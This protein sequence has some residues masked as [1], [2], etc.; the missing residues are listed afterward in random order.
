MAVTSVSKEQY[1]IHDVC[2]HDEVIGIGY[3]NDIMSSV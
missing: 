3:F 2:H 1:N